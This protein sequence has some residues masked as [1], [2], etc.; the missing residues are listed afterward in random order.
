MKDGFEIGGA[1]ST[2][3]DVCVS[4]AAEEPP[5]CPTTQALDFPNS[6]N[7]QCIPVAVA[8]QPSVGQNYAAR[9]QERSP[10]EGPTCDPDDPTRGWKQALDEARADLASNTISGLGRTKWKLIAVRDYLKGDDSTE[11]VTVLT[12]VNEALKKITV[13]EIASVQGNVDILGVSIKARSEAGHGKLE[14]DDKVG[15]SQFRGEHAIEPAVKGT[16]EIASTLALNAEGITISEAVD[17]V[18][19]GVRY[20]DLFSGTEFARKYNLSDSDLERMRESYQHLEVYRGLKDDPKTAWVTGMLTDVD[21]F[22]RDAVLANARV[23]MDHGLYPLAARNYAFYFKTDYARAGK[24]L[25]AEKFIR[26]N[27]P[28]RSEEYLAILRKRDAGEPVSRDEIEKVG[29]VIRAH[30]HELDKIVAGY[31]AKGLRAHDYEEARR[32][33][34]T[35]GPAAARL[36][37]GSFISGAM[38]MIG[39]GGVAH[40]TPADYGVSK[41]DAVWAEYDRSILLSDGRGTGLLN[42]NAAGNERIWRDAIVEGSLLVASFGSGYIVSMGVKEV[43]KRTL[44]KAVFKGLARRGLAVAAEEAMVTGGADAL[45]KL[46]AKALGASFVAAKVGTHLVEF[47][48][49]VQ[50]ANVVNVLYTGDVSRFATIF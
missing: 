25:P 42:R 35:Y 40:K 41:D 30:R 19:N 2:P 13:L 38:I 32:L 20:K 10:F 22:S 8:N 48:A 1:V 21:T 4:Q 43:A 17:E 23:Y 34:A 16:F 46:G 18:V 49:F 29:V 5:A 7:C 31:H 24:E 14:R 3:A 15:F 6:D 36:S 45:L 28:E 9:L 12:E 50:G 44:V 37:G 39:N 11:A 33:Q 27:Y 47:E 26:D